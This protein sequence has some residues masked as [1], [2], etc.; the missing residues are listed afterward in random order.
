MRTVVVESLIKPCVEYEASYR[1]Y[2][3][4]LGDEVR[5][6]FPLDF[7]A[8]DF[9]AL[10][11]RLADLEAG[12]NLPD[13]RVPSSTYWLVEDGEIVGISNLRHFLNDE[14]RHCGGHIGLGVR[15]LQRGQGL[16]VRLLQLT[17]DQARQIGIPEVHV[18]CYRWNEASA[19]MI[20]RCGGMLDSEVIKD[21]SG[22]VVRRY[23]IHR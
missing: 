2:I 11:N 22:E 16:G 17:V 15:P 3:S 9:G 7:D 21:Q 20:E 5:Y 10:L 18:H 13:G 8:S 6:P 1:A 23:V 12:I 14:L 4:E 19:R